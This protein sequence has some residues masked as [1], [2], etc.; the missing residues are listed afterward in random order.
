VSKEVN[1]PTKH[2]DRLASGLISRGAQRVHVPAF[3]NIVNIGALFPVILLPL[4]S[5]KVFTAADIFIFP[6]FTEKL[7]YFIL[8]TENEKAELS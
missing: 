6:P 2:C 4:I 5:R 7:S 8:H 1:K 3:I